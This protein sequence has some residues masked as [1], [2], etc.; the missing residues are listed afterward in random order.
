MDDSESRR[1][2][3]EQIERAAEQRKRDRGVFSDRSKPAEERRMA[4]QSLSAL[5]DEDEVAEAIDNIRDREEDAELRAA[6]LRTIS[7]EVG[8]R[9]DLI[10]FAI[11]LLRDKTESAVV[12]LVHPQRGLC[13]MSYSSFHET[14]NF[15]PGTVEKGARTARSRAALQRCLRDA[16]L[17]DPF[18]Q[19]PRTVSPEDSRKPRMRLPNGAQCHPSLQRARPRRPRP[20]LLATQA[21]PRRFRRERRRGP[22][23]DAPPLPE[24]VRAQ[25]EPVDFGY[26]RRGRL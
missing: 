11:D 19:R 15:C 24:G 21:R 5:T 12:R 4:L 7:A 23:A 13:V 17:P 10:D 6:A 16:S 26:G 14:S 25:L 8:Q 22:Q 1:Q 18:G 20:R 3:A 9:H 2:Y